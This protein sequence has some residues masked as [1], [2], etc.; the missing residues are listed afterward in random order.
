M[1][2]D[3]FKNLSND[4]QE[5][6]VKISNY[7]NGKATNFMSFTSDVV[8]NENQCKSDE[9]AGVVIEKPMKQ[10]IPYAQDDLAIKLNSHLYFNTCHPIDDDVLVEYKV[11]NGGTINNDILLVNKPGTYTIEANATYNNKTVN[12]KVEVIVELGNE[13]QINVPELNKRALETLISACE[14]LDL[15]NYSDINKDN[16][17]KVLDDAKKLLELENLN[18]AL[19]DEMVLKL[20]DARD[21]L[22]KI[23]FNAEDSEVSKKG[24]WV[25]LSESTLD[26]GTAFKIRSCQ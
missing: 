1:E 2:I 13:P 26:K 22:T 8:S 24:N 4:N 15:D 23:K 25:T 6:L 5:Y 18:Q 16:F 3:D 19:I 10:T 17:I 9:L 21:A 20:T 11:D 12:D 7:E 14:A